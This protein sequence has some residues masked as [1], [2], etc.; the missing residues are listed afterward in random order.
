MEIR[1]DATID[2]ED[3]ANINWIRF[4]INAALSRI[5]DAPQKRSKG[6]IMI[7]VQSKAVEYQD[8]IRE[9]MDKL[10]FKGIVT[11]CY[12]LN[13]T[14]FIIKVRLSHHL[15]VEC[16]SQLS[17]DSEV[18]KKSAAVADFVYTSESNESCGKTF[19]TKMIG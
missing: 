10:L 2:N 6:S 17:I 12:F 1:F 4:Y 19:D 7:A 18:Y 13:R 15:C 11:G 14:L 8:K 9:A 3:L 5:P 16:F